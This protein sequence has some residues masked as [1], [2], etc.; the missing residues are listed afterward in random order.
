[1]NFLYNP[2]NKARELLP[3]DRKSSD[4][5]RDDRCVDHSCESDFFFFVVPVES[6]YKDHKKG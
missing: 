2:G 1:M 4:Y 5:K 3:D 6:T